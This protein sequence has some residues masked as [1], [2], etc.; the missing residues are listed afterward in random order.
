MYPPKVMSY[1]DP[2]PNSSP[3]SPNCITRMVFPISPVE[4]A[5]KTGEPRKN[6]YEANFGI[7]KSAIF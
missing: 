7:K 5:Q 1:S 6:W 3:F 2:L 4:L